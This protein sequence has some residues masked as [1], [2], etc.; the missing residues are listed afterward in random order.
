MPGWGHLQASALQRIDRNQGANTSFAPTRVEI[1]TALGE[2]SKQWAVN[3]EQKKHYCEQ[4]PQFCFQASLCS[5]EHDDLYGKVIW[6]M[7]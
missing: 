7:R 4:P 2:N 5:S 3:G 6:N 1:G